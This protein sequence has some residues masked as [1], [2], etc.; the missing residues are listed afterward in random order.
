MECLQNLDAIADRV[1][2]AATFHGGGIATT[3]ADSPHLLVPQMKAQFLHAVAQS[4]DMQDPNAKV[5]LK[6][7]FDK[8]KLPAEIEVYSGAAHGWCPPDSGVYNEPQA[9]KA[10][11]RLLALYSKALA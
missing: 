6:E 9:E 10:W 4:D 5:R 7:A 8:A 11:T 2:G 3:A 1:G